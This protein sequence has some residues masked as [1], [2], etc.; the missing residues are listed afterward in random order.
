[1][2]KHIVIIG[3]GV[4]GTS[5]AY[6]LKQLGYKVTIVEKN[7]RLGGRIHSVKMDDVNVELGAAFLTNSYYNVL[8]FIKEKGLDKQLFSQKSEA[9]VFKK[10]T[11]LSPT[12]LFLSLSL[13][14]KVLFLKLLITV[15]L[16]W[17][18]I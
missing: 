18:H 15:L 6:H 10:N 11:F 8:S 12:A 7:D 1:M 17:S 16:L 14:S 13:Q 5:A 2:G 4:A 3:G 9:R